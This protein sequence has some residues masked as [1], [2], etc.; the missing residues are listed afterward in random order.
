[1]AFTRYWRGLLL[2][3]SL[4]TTYLLPFPIRQ[5]KLTLPGEANSLSLFIVNVNF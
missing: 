2:D 3:L 5:R 1:V 4:P